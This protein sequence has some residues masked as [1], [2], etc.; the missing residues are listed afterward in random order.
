MKKILRIMS[1][2]RAEYS[3]SKKL[4]KK[5][6]EQLLAMHPG[7]VI[8][9]RD[10]V[11]TPPPYLQHQHIVSFFKDPADR[12]VADMDVLAYSD[13]VVQEV[14]EA[15]IIIIEAPMYNY[16]IDARLKSWADQLLRIG[17][18][19]GYNA[20]GKRIGLVQGKEAYIA[21]SSGG[22]Y[23]QGETPGLDFV[24]PY[25]RS[26]LDFIGISNSRVVRVEGV[27]FASLSE[28]EI[29]IFAKLNN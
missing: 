8:V 2:P 18:T 15:D 19:F 21:M 4:G 3:N 28:E 24:A 6:T 14:F 1:S 17:V 13:G 5:L 11:A 25:L 27:L 7:S 23:S 22:V 16:G 10:L 26:I 9:E 12:T 29:A 20:E